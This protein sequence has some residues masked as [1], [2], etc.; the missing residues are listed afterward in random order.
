[1]R[2]LDIRGNVETRLGKLESEDLDAVILAAAGLERMA[3]S[4]RVTE[5]LPAERFLPA[6]GQGAL[7]IEVRCGDTRVLERVRELEHGKSRSAVT[8]ERA[9]LGVLGGGCRVPI[10]VWARMEARRLVVDGMV[11][12]PDGSRLVRGQGRG[13]PGEPEELGKKLAD[14]LIERG[15]EEILDAVR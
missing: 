1:V 2:P 7:A 4:G 8:A 11:A 14:D 13:D 15:A 9:T 3:L 12:H 5:F 6:P 10:G